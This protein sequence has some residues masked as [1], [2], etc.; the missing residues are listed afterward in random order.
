M[1]QRKAD[2]ESLWYRERRM[3]G[4]YGTGKADDGSLW[5]RKMQ[6]MGHYGTGKVR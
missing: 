3:M 2:D 5:Y 4:H 1:V 6:I